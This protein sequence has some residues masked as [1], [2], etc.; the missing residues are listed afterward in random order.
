MTDI[1]P[2][3]DGHS[4]ESVPE[5]GPPKTLQRWCHPASAVPTLKSG[6]LVYGCALLLGE[7]WHFSLGHFEMDRMGW[8][9]VTWAKEAS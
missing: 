3:A 4:L 5:A 7:R 9:C 2:K 1:K 8:E 6:Q